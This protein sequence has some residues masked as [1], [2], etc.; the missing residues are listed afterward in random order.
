[1]ANT[2]LKTLLKTDLI[3]IIRGNLA[4]SKDYYLFVSRATAYEDVV[5]T[6]PVESD[7]NP[8]SIGESSRNAYDTYRNMIFLKRLNAD[9][10]RL[11]I[12]RVDWTAGTAYT[13]YSET[14]DMAGK[15]YYVLTTEFNVYKCMAASGLSQIMP[16]GKSPDVISLGD[17]YKW[18]YI[19]SVPE[20][21]I[22]FITLE[23]IP[24]FTA[25]EGNDEQKEVQDT[26]LPGSIDSIT[27]NSTLS[28]TFDKIFRNTRLISNIHASTIRS[29]LG[30]TVNAAGSS[31]I[32]FVPAGEENNPANDYWNNYAIYISEG[33]GVGQYFRIL[34]FTKGGAGISYFYANVTPSIE[35]TIDNTS[36]FKIV[37]YMVVDG[38]GQD[39]VVIPATSNAKKITGLSVVNP[40]RNYT[41]A[42]PRVVS[43]IGSVSIGSQIATFNDSVSANLSTPS[44]HG[45][46]AI[47]EFG[48]ADLMVVV[49][50]NGDEGGKFSVRNDFRQF[51][52]VKK[53]YLYGG[54]TYAGQ[55]EVVVLKA[56]IKKQPNKDDLYELSTFVPGNYIYGTDTRSTAKIVDSERIPGSRLYRLYVSDPVGN[57]RFSEDSST[58]T[59]VHYNT[60]YTG[61]FATGDTV[62]QYVGTIGL[63]LSASGEI[64][65]YDSYGK[66]F[67][68][69]TAF[70]AFVAGKTMTFLSGGT[71]NA[72]AIVD[73]DE[74]FGEMLKQ[75]KFGQ[76]SGS[77]F[78]KFSG[79][80]NFGR[81]ASTAFLPTVVEDVGEYSTTTKIRIVSSGSPFTDGVLNSS[82]AIDGTIRQTNSTSLRRTTGDIID[83]VVPGG[84]GL[85][86]TIH[87]SNIKGFF[88]SSDSLYFT[89]SGTTNETQLT[90]I[91]INNIQ[92]SDIDIGSG[93]LLYIENVRP[94]E[95]NIEQT[96]QFKIVIG[97]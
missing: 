6:T 70:G 57:F 34:D 36:A 30:I 2:A 54:E 65:S 51:G 39:A 32:S 71:L 73:V 33:A 45:A 14:T 8:P 17:G 84:L 78:L 40:G 94:V 76:T 91:S 58:K 90:S 75:V 47:K 3:D 97:F 38:D 31:Y 1:M 63:T 68:I 12:P 24:V 52:I 44:G 64:L 82:N 80:E 53:P 74:E 86:G 59:R 83:F 72:N 23:Y 46:N 11:V 16:T 43:D 93:E 26:T 92:N 10:M 27:L 18:K 13:A 35:R 37:P 28:P 9:N 48:A 56:L 69:D 20:N 19:Y 81:L 85:T 61:T 66:N 50:L 42:K 89:P 22:E 15:T 67:L 5:G 79:D 60:L 96:E 87:L 29:E 41:Y 95:R 7:T 49:E 4:A 55:E 25:H 77:E 21:D 88:N 62:N